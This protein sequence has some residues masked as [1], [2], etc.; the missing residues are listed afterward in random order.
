M[1]LN[2]NQ[3]NQNEFLSILELL[4][5]YTKEELKDILGVFK[6]EIKEITQSLLKASSEN[7]N[8]AAGH[9]CHQLK[10]V[11]LSLNLDNLSKLTVEIENCFK[12]NNTQDAKEKI[13]KLNQS[14]GEL[15]LFLEHQ[16]W[17]KD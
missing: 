17:F 16:G 9:L 2:L 3:N 11:F 14:I 7:Q 13:K 12:L 5:T 4:N 8:E 15:L 6:S 1:E 10:G